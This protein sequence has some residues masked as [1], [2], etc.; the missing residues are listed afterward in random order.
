MGSVH[1]QN[2][3]DQ[4]HTVIAVGRAKQNPTVPNFD[5]GDDL[6]KL[7]EDG[8]ETCVIS[9]PETGAA[10]EAIRAME[11]G[12]KKILLDKPGAPRS[13]E[14]VKVQQ[15]A[16]Q[17]GVEL[18]MNYQR[19]MDPVFSEK[20]Q[21][22]TKKTAEGFSLDYVSVY[23]C[24][25]RQPPQAAPQPLNQACH[26]FAMLL[27]I[28]EAAGDCLAPT[29]MKTEGINWNTLSD[30]QYMVCTGHAESQG[31]Q[32]CLYEVKC[33]R[34]SSFGSFTEILV[35]MSRYN[36]EDDM[37]EPFEVKLRYP[38]EPD[39]TA[40]WSDVWKDAFVGVSKEFTSDE[41]QGLADA[42]LGV[43]VLRMA[44]LCN[45]SLEQGGRQLE[46]IA[47]SGRQYPERTR[48]V[49]LGAGAGINGEAL[50]EA[51]DHDKTG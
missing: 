22:V 3:V 46:G 19:K 6:R 14:L 31:G 5:A 18:C 2:L 44:E 13:T 23:S 42:E 29:S 41:P 8:Y 38:E 39:P 32:K 43:R 7:V 20:L 45:I 36:E 9:I 4:G 48:W 16:Q 28:F 51:L 27:D 47:L 26:D 10:Q 33:G 35:K 40:H 49:T 12:F 34:V 30:T 15:A 17:H 11:A 21:E 1:T 50:V 25:A 37:Y 24:D